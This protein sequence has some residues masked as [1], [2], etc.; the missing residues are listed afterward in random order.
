MILSAAAF[1]LAQNIFFEARGEDLAGKAAV[2][3]VTLN[4]VESKY[5]PDNVCDVVF[6][7]KQFS[8][9]HD[10]K[11]DNPEEYNTHF[12][13]EAWIVSKDVAIALLSGEVEEDLDGALWYHADY[14]NPYWASSYNQVAV[15]GK[16]VFYN[17]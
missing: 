5:Y 10:G 12:D 9:T 6:Q 3:V 7:R 4:R 14:V 11:S 17:K 15:I 2:G 16:H 1:C 13:R 8:W